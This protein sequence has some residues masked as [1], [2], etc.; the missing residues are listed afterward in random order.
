MQQK[1]LS[2]ENIIIKFSEM[3]FYYNQIHQRPKT[4]IMRYVYDKVIHGPGTPALE[5]VSSKL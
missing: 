2:Y 4:R 5:E 3:F 1:A